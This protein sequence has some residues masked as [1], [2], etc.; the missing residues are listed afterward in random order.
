MLLNL[1]EEMNSVDVSILIDTELRLFL[2]IDQIFI[3]S[4]NRG[5]YT[6]NATDYKQ[7]YLFSCPY[8]DTAQV[9]NIMNDCAKHWDTFRSIAQLHSRDVS[10]LNGIFIIICLLNRLNREASVRCGIYDWLV[11]YLAIGKMPPILPPDWVMSV[12]LEF[13]QFILAITN[14]DNK[15]HFG[16]SFISIKRNEVVVAAT[17]CLQNMQPQKY[18]I[19]RAI[20]ERILM[21]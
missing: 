5:R 17:F 1:T 6:T 9:V 21:D 8:I 7:I 3:Y 2:K 12:P 18:R 20:A 11:C 14:G 19:E 15:D 4:G 10:Q 16:R 13:H